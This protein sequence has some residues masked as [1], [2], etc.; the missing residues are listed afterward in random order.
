MPCLDAVHFAL[1]AK[2]DEIAGLML[3]FLAKQKL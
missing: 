3:D 2:V 1:D